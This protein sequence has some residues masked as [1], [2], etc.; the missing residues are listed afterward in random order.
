MLTIGII[1]CCPELNVFYASIV[2]RPGFMQHSPESRYSNLYHI[3]AHIAFVAQ[4]NL[5]NGD[6]RGKKKHCPALSEKD[7][8]Q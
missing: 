3:E 2:C 6:A 8:T 5:E 1:N 7:N 4:N